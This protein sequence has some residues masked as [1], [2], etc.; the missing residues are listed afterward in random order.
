MPLSTTGNTPVIGRSPAI[1][2]KR[3]WNSRVRQLAV[4]RCLPTPPRAHELVAKPLASRHFLLFA[5]SCRSTG[6]RASTRRGRRGPQTQNDAT[7]VGG[8]FPPLTTHGSVRSHDRPRS[9]RPRDVAGRRSSRPLGGAA[10]LWVFTAWEAPA[11][12]DRVWYARTT[13]LSV[14]ASSGASWR[15]RLPSRCQ[16]GMRPPACASQLSRAPDRRPVSP[17]RTRT[18]P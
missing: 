17:P 7:P 1:R 8:T 6:Y 18:R 9:H 4:P 11:H 15:R 14:S 13:Y 2:Y 12:R 5:G 10:P 16:P 3:L